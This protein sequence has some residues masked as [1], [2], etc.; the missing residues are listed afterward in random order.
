MPTGWHYMQPVSY[1]ARGQRIE[2]SSYK[3]LYKLVENWRVQN[4][5]EVGDV[6][7]DIDDYIC[8]TYPHQCGKTYGVAQH[9]QQGRPGQKFVDKISNWLLEMTKRNPSVLLQAEAQKRADICAQCPLNQH[10]ENKCGACMSNITRLGTILR[11]NNN[12]SIAPSLHGCN[13]LNQDNKTAVWLD[14][15]G[16]GIA[17][18]QLPEHCWA[19]KK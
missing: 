8:N 11:K 17:N 15:Y 7:R 14:I 3:E 1:N 2:A 13:V 19:K 18:T 6:K 5:I 9:K 10:Y 12:L 16:D 4:G